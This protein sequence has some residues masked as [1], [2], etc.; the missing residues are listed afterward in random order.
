ML[1]DFPQNI[2]TCSFYFL[3]PGT[4]SKYK[5]VFSTYR[6]CLAILLLAD[7]RLHV[8]RTGV[9]LSTEAAGWRIRGSPAPPPLSYHQ[10]DYPGSSLVPGCPSLPLA[11]PP[12]T[13]SSPP[14]HPHTHTLK[15][16]VCKSAPRRA[17]HL[18]SESRLAPPQPPKKN[19]NL[20]NV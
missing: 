1:S 19:K 14:I 7:T 6:R 18:F 8:S 9:F 15:C 3:Q 16:T 20:F 10:S 11:S 4:H 5:Q 12:L 2:S 13:I 17:A